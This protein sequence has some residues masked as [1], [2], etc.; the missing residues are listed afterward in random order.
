MPFGLSDAENTNSRGNTANATTAIGDE[1]PPPGVGEP[2]AEAALAAGRSGLLAQ[3]REVG[4]GHRWISSRAL[5]L[6][7]LITAIS[8]TMMKMRIEKADARP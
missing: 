2:A 6:L 7:K 4:G 1:V 3:V 5:V 8:A